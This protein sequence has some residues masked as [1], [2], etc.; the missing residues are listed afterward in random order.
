MSQDWNATKINW[1]GGG[2]SGTVQFGNDALT[3]VMFYN[4]SV[5]IPAK[6]IEM[7]RRWFEDQIYVT[8]QHPG[9]NLN[10]IDRPATDQD[11]MRYRSQW[12]AFVQNR[13]QIPEG[14]T[15]DLLFPNHPS[16][17]ENLKAM[18]VY[19]IEQ[20]AKLSASAIDNIGRGGQEYVNRAQMYLSSAEKG[21]AFHKLQKQIDDERV[22]KRVLQQQVADLKR[23]LD[24]VLMRTG[25]QPLSAFV[26]G[27]Q[28]DEQSAR[29]N[30]NH[31]TQ[32]LAKKRKKKVQPVEIEPDPITDPLHKMQPS[33][34]D[35]LSN[36]P[37]IG[38]TDHQ[39]ASV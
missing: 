33:I 2:L 10:K 38:S 9:E 30:A 22:E 29:I 36:N 32:E 4:K 25:N 1:N 20:C 34:H 37:D 19:T 31:P 6:S 17:G 28:H 24:Q 16:V 8:I 13:T 7:G 39:D 23:Q 26:P 18:G 21:K 5:E 14:T 35:E 3:L 27:P 12:S 11:K 15:I